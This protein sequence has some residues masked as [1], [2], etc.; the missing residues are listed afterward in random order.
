MMPGMDGLQA[1]QI[2]KSQKQLRHI[3]VIAMTARAMQEDRDKAMQAGCDD[4]LTKPFEMDDFLAMVG[5][6]V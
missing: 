1:T 5:K 2:L 3:P 4:F 6:Y